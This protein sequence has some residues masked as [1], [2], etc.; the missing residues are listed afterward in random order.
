MQRTRERAWFA[1]PLLRRLHFYAGVLVA[2]FLVVAA[3]TGL[4]Y[5]FTPQLDS[6]VY[7]DELRVAAVA[8]PARPLAEQV[9]SARAA[10]P[11]GTL[12]TVI[13][14]TAPDTTTQVVFALPELGDR[15]HTVYV[16]P[17]TARVRGTLVTWF[18]STPLTTWLDDLHRNLHLGWFGRMYSSWRRAGSGCWSPVDWCSGSGNTDGVGP[19]CGAHCCPTWPRATYAVPGVGMPPPG[20]GSASA[21]WCSPRPV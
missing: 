12:T 21:C 19:A 6:L 1:V 13:P 10:H 15:Q 2:P 11:T 16:D 7:A 20:S 17:Y 4:A 14:A 3:L 5:V 9:A 8:G 18:G